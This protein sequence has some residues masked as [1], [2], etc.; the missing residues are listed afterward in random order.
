MDLE[1]LHDVLNGYR[2]GQFD[3]EAAVQKINDL[4]D[5][6]GRLVQFIKEL[7][8]QEFANGSD[9]VA[10]KLL[11]VDLVEQTVP[12]I[13]S[14]VFCI[15]FDSLIAHINDDRAIGHNGPHSGRQG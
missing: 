4:D 8:E 12:D 6:G 2:D 13:A 3:L 5:E 9:Q 1:K 10:R 11:A 14:D 7:S 15:Y